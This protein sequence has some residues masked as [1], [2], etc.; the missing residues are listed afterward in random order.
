MVACLGGVALEG[1]AI[2]GRLDG[3]RLLANVIPAQIR[4]R[5]RR[6]PCWEGIEVFLVEVDS[7]RRG[8]V[9]YYLWGGIIPM[10]AVRVSD[11]AVEHLQWGIFLRQAISNAIF[12]HL[13]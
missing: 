7:S 10:G 9:P 2:G 6:W 13:A 8:G 12:M 3:L 1:E 5:Q 11:P 4:L